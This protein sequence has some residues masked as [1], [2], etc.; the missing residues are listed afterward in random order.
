MDG[1]DPC[2]IVILGG[3]PAGSVAEMIVARLGARTMLIDKGDPEGR[4]G[5][6]CPLG[7]IVGGRDGA[8]C[9]WPE[10]RRGSS[11]RSRVSGSRMQRI[12]AASGPR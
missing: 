11:I 12:L 7:M 9:C 4:K 1:E 10:T 3:G 8:M 5:N 2:G 6:S